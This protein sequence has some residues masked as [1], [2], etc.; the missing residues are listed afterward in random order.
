MESECR[1]GYHSFDQGPQSLPFCR[2]RSASACSTCEQC[3]RLQGQG[4]GGF[5]DRELDMHHRCRPHLKSKHY[6]AHQH[7][8]VASTPASFSCVSKCR[9]PLMML[10]K[11]QRQTTHAGNQELP[12]QHR[13]SEPSA[14]LEMAPAVASQTRTARQRGQRLPK[15]DTLQCLPLVTGL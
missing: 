12:C 10:P 2:F 3:D 4:S 14:L 1:V 9:E 6:M 13:S 8:P 5:E 7:L 11:I 15:S